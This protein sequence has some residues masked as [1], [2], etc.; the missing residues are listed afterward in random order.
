MA[1]K[2][3][4]AIE[5]GA[6]RPV[7]AGTG[8][9]MDGWAGGRNLAKP[10]GAGEGG[11]RHKSLCDTSIGQTKQGKSNWR[12][13]RRASW[14]IDQRLIRLS[15]LRTEVLRETAKARVMLSLSWKPRSQYVQ[16]LNMAQN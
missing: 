8:D 10:G 13:K 15:I 1:C 12:S 9:Q 14:L 7:L 4:K 16:P 2:A 5:K 6:S 11:G 3:A